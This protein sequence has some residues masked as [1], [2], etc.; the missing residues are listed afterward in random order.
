MRTR[1]A[2]LLLASF[3]SFIGVSGL[4]QGPAAAAAPQPDDRFKADLLLIVAHPD[5]DVLAGTYL[6]NAV[7]DQGKRVAVVFATSGDSGGNQAGAE[8]GASLG[9]MRQ[10]EARQ[11]LATLGITHVWFLSGHDTPGQD[12]VR[13]L[14]NWGH[15]QVLGEA[16]RIVR[17]TR[18]EVV[19]TWLPMQ[20]I[21]E[22]HGDHQAASVVATEAF[23][24]AGDPAAYPEQVSEPVERFES[25]LEGLR[26]WQP[27]KLYFMSDALDTRFMTGH[28]P[29]YSVKEISKAKGVPYWQLAFEQLNAHVTQYKTMLAQLASLDAATRERVAV[30]DTGGDALI[31]PLRLVRAKSHV[32]GTAEG[33]IFEGITPAPIPLVPRPREQAARP[34]LALRVGGPWQFYRDFWQAHALPALT[35]SADALIGPVDQDEPVS[36]PLLVINGTDR[37]AEVQ[38]G[39]ALP[40]G[41]HEGPRSAT[42]LVAAGAQVQIV[43]VVTPAD[44]DQTPTAH[45]LTYTARA[46]GATL[47]P[48][49]VRVVVVKGA[50]PLP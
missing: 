49:S 17:L 40:Q 6:A 41:W 42:V 10:I 19:L 37:D 33:D 4:A 36:I 24:L 27:K 13:S 11:D 26:P 45:D 3:F 48:V 25:H 16:L 35:M 38:V 9:L 2:R 21:G 1:L 20:V 50:S 5:D 31:E 44:A 18:P 34:A 46:G 15:G 47:P 32:G 14:A 28:G 39:A 22:N 43:S 30:G 8:R 23:D 29:A 12:P 7:L